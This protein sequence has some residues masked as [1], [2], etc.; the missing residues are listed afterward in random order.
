MNKFFKTLGLIVVLALMMVVLGTQV[1]QAL[2]DAAAP[3][4]LPYGLTSQDTMATV[5]QKLGQPKVTFASQAGWEAGL[6]DEGSSP[7]HMHYWA[8]YER[9]GLTIVYNTPSASDKGA[10]INAIYVNE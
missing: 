2:R 4:P 3:A 5:E 1:V 7:D 9:F 6:P 8:I 10:T